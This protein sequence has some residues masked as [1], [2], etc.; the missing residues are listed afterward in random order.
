MN[1]IDLF[2][3]SAQS[4]KVFSFIGM[5]KN[6]GKTTTYNYIIK[7]LHSKFV[8]GL[9]SIGRDGE[10]RDILTNQ[11][12]P[13]IYV[14]KGN[15]LATAL[16]SL[17]RSIFNYEVISNTDIP[18][19][20]GNIIIVKAEGSGTIELSGP[21]LIQYLRSTCDILKESGADLVLIDGAF[22]RKSF[23]SPTVANAT[24][25]ATGAALSHDMD[26]VVEETQFSISKLT[27]PILQDSKTRKIISE[28]FLTHKAGLVDFDHTIYPF[29]VNT[30]LNAT[31][32]IIETISD[33]THY[34]VIKGILSSDL[35]EQLLKRKLD[36]SSLSIVVEDGTKIFIREDLYYRFLKKQGTINVL[37][38]IKII[39]IS[40]NPVSPYGVK[41]N[42]K[43]FLSRL[44]KHIDIPV[45]DVVSGG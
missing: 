25:L 1:L 34:I 9:T 8:L 23:A 11:P 26:E 43:E 16:E 28:F 10:Q 36:L 45:F 38:P 14:S 32:E 19:A 35:I 12:K 7:N 5:A 6:V 20:L 39:A 40:A 24:I 3:E 44:R 4:H 41:F 31:T 37:N 2:L 30:A 17:D 22:D 18:S 13:E 15:I 42:Q 21:S 29:N 33:K 27:T